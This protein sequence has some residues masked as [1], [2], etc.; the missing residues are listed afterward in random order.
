MRPFHDQTKHSY[1]SVRQSSYTIDWDHQP[2]RFKHYPTTFHQLSLD[3]STPLG[4]MIYLFSAITASKCYPGVEYHLRVNPS[5]GALYP[6]ELYIVTKNVPTIPNGCYHLDTARASLVSLHNQWD[7]DGWNDGIYIMISALYHRSSW[8]Y[9]DRALRYIFLDAGHCLGAIEAS[10]Y[11]HGYHLYWLY[12]RDKLALRTSLSLQGDEWLTSVLYCSID[13]SLSKPYLSPNPSFQIENCSLLS[14]KANEF[15]E[16]ALRETSHD[17]QTLK[18]FL[19]EAPYKELLTSELIVKRRSIRNFV[20]RFGTPGI[21]E[22]IQKCLQDV[23]ELISLTM[24]VH[25]IDGISS[26]LYRDGICLKKGVFRDQC[27]YLCLEQALGSDG[28]MTCFITSSP[29]TPYQEALLAA[30]LVGHRIYL[31]SA[32]HGFGCSG[33]G[34]FYD[35]EVKK[36]INNFDDILYALAIG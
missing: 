22:D 31:L 9:R 4:R 19:L 35:D 29:H 6:N 20:Y 17:N 11:L 1:T 15:I 26:G 18:P 32:I 33:I 16:K 24:I 27:G 34:A 25:G 14:Y 36:F 12:D 3:L 7:S 28:I 5:A 8:K 2:E 21:F 23:S 13:K 10:S 30:G